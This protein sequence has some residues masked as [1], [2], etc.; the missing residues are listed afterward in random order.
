MKKTLKKTLTLVAL[1]LGLM[2][3]LLYILFGESYEYY[4]IQ[5]NLEKI[6]VDSLSKYYQIFRIENESRD[7]DEVDFFN[8]LTDKNLILK[9]QLSKYNIKLNSEF[10]SNQKNVFKGFYHIGPDDVDDNMENLLVENDITSLKGDILLPT[11]NYYNIKTNNIYG[12]RNGEVINLGIFNP[13]SIVA[14]SIPCEGN[15]KIKLDTIDFG[16][17]IIRFHNQKSS[18]KNEIDNETL[19][20]ILNDSLLKSIV[21]INDH[22]YIPFNTYKPKSYFYCDENIDID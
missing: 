3:F 10:V 19:G 17:N 16:V 15:V 18:I 12:I 22:L 20:I 21:K 9:N 11:K 6:N 8:F 14:K 2:I 1:L 4:K 5:S 7:Y 13:I